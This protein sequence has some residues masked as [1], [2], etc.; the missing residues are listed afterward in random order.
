MTRT[1]PHTP[2]RVGFTFAL[3][4]TVLLAAC[5]KTP[6]SDG[7]ATQSAAAAPTT[8][9]A[10]PLGCPTVRDAL[11]RE[12]RFLDSA[13]PAALAVADVD[14]CA[15]AT[16]LVAHHRHTA[17][18]G[19]AEL[20]EIVSD[21]ADQARLKDMLSRM[22]REEIEADPQSKKVFNLLAMCTGAPEEALKIG[23]RDMAPVVYSVGQIDLDA[24]RCPAYLFQLSSTKLDSI[25]YGLRLL[26]SC[27]AANGQVENL[28]TPELGNLLTASAYTGALPAKDRLQGT[29][30]AFVTRSA[31][32]SSTPPAGRG[33]GAN[34]IP[35]QFVGTWEQDA[36]SCASAR[37]LGG[38]TDAGV[39]ITTTDIGSTYMGCT[40][41]TVAASSADAFMGVFDC[42][43]EGET[44]EATRS[45]RLSDGR[46]FLDQSMSP[47]IR[48]D[49][50]G[51]HT[52][53]A[54]VEPRP[55][56]T[57][58]PSAPAADGYQLSADDRQVV[59][60][61]QELSAHWRQ[62]GPCE[63]LRQNM[64]IVATTSHP[65]HIRIQLM[66][67]AF[68]KAYKYNCIVE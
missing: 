34:E 23:L 9:V 28:R 49:I 8:T 11:D 22:T 5:G 48:C 47:Y 51:S 6:P 56:A 36:A 62:T 66:D 39:Q 20:C 55:V 10:K 30:R 40:L 57:V 65:A 60:Y 12:T 27:A 7:P 26:G 58:R 18:R 44:S 1:C 3:V 4:A 41:R 50:A 21:P 32:S 67:R 24:A 52:N 31:A 29:D 45:L 68:D 42:S 54:T 59:A 61:A 64:L 19:F 15:I 63:A 17:E 46:L 35:A 14:A 2:S 53:A 33:S 43:E 13:D 16:D 25:G 37:E 38:A